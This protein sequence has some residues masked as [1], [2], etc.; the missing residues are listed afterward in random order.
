MTKTKSVTVFHVSPQTKR[1]HTEYFYKTRRPLYLLV[2]PGRGRLGFR[3]S[4]HEVHE[5]LHQQP[6]EGTEDV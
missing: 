4:L 1:T 3:N 6:E 2:L 5:L